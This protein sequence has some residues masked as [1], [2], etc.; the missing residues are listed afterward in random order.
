MGISISTGGLVANKNIS[1][2]QNIYAEK[3][4]PLS[5]ADCRKDDFPGTIC[6]YYEVKILKAVP[7]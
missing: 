2:W 3:G 4:F 6:Y 7:W 5:V 1:G